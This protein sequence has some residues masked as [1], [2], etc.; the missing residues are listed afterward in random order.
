MAIPVTVRCPVCSRDAPTTKRWSDT[1]LPPGAVV[2]VHVHCSCGVR[3]QAAGCSA[4]GRT[5]AE[6]DALEDLRRA[7]RTQKE[8]G[9]RHGPH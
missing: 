1:A 2:Y 7:W 3:M 8:Q 9:E 5:D 4:N 6:R